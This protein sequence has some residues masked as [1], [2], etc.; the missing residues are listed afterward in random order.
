MP[1]QQTPS[2]V[3]VCVKNGGKSQ[4]AAG[5]MRRATGESVAV[6]CAGTHPGTTVNSLSAQSLL[7]VG[8]DIAGETPK[9][10]DP[11]L[12]RDVHL[13]ITLG[14]E[15][16]IDVPGATRVES[17]DIDEPSERGIEGIVHMRL[18]R[19]DIATRVSDL[20]ARLLTHTSEGD[21]RMS[22]IQVFEPALC[23]NTGVC[24]EDVDQALVTFSADM[25]WARS[26][27]GDVSRYNLASEPMAFAEN[28]T[29]KQFLQ[30]AGSE[31][32]PLVLVDGVTVVTGSYPDRGSLARW[33]GI[34]VPAIAAAPAGI[35]MLGLTDADAGGACCST[36][37]SGAT[38]CC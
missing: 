8:V 15:A 5:L 1:V 23:C 22:T 27:G 11:Q 28:D 14:R 2:V 32:L 34:D 30:L 24:G 37:S 7:E 12:L 4:M 25:D 20:A 17:W 3:F 6:H 33:T 29:V 35:R 10:I 13:V 38:T 9:C 31:R 36:G 19:D 26:H 16:T 21:L 18:V